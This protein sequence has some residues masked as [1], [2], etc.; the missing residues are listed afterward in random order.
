MELTKIGMRGKTNDPLSQHL[1]SSSFQGELNLMDTCQEDMA[2]HSSHVH[3]YEEIKRYSPGFNIPHKNY[4]TIYP[5]HSKDD[6]HQKGNQNIKSTECWRDSNNKDSLATK[7]TVGFIL[8]VSL[9]SLVLV[10]L[11]V[12]GVI[13]PKCVCNSNFSKFR[14]FVYARSFSF[15]S[16]SDI[17]L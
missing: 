1:P 10:F 15:V 2:E 4:K 9:T 8:V 7:L 16:Y 12:V 17:F 6:P 5:K 13:G 3:E 14:F 11:D